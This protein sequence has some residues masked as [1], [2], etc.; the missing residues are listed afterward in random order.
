[1]ARC[2]FAT[3]EAVSGPVGRH[4]NGP[5]KIVHHTTE[6]PTYETARHTYK[7]KKVD[8]HFT[9]TGS[10]VYQHIDTSMSAR[11]LKNAPGGVQTNRDSAVQIEVVGYAARPK[12]AGTLKTT[13]RLCRWIEK[14]HHIPQQWPNGP[15]R[16]SENGKDPGGHNRNAAN[17]NDRSG[18][19]G[20][21]QVPENSHW[22][23][24][25]TPAELTLVTPGA[26]FDSHDALEATALR[27]DVDGGKSATVD[28][29]A[30]RVVSAVAAQL[31]ARRQAYKQIN[32]RVAIAGMEVEVRVEGAA[33]AVDATTTRRRRS[34]ASA[35]RR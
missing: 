16:W 11:A 4:L 19:F 7:A 6:G 30:V 24:G 27:T 9:V 5:Y 13:A 32:V 20:H 33:K 15:T 18:H 2:P 29:V 17:W 22:D 23:P 35:K 8:P 12:D 25:Y 14:E 26:T 31:R 1:V 3:W 34:S 21:S 10:V 28:E